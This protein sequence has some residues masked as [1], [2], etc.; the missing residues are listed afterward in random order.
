M[1]DRRV[2]GNNGVE[3]T[4]A[5]WSG[6]KSE[7]MSYKSAQLHIK[8]YEV[9]CQT[10]KEYS[11]FPEKGN[12]SMECISIIIRRDVKCY[13]DIW[14]RKNFKKGLLRVTFYLY[15]AGRGGFVRF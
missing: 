4:V 10:E 5:V 8:P 6:G 14:R 1:L 7:R 11:S 12:D 2:C 15:E 9:C 13:T 3:G